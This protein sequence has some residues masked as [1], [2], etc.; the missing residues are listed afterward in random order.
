MDAIGYWAWDRKRFELDTPPRIPRPY[1]TQVEKSD[2]HVLPGLPEMEIDL[3]GKP[4]DQETRGRLYLARVRQE[5]TVRRSLPY[6]YT[7]RK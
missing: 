4:I 1:G 3:L 7:T 2:F 5:T 6:R